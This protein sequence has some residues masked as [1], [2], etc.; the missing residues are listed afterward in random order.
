MKKGPDLVV[1]VISAFVLGTVITGV[2]HSD[3]EF[4][5]LVGQVLN[6]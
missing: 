3:I 5:A 2:S 4:I 6:G 1:V